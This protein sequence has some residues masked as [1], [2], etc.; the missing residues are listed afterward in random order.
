MQDQWQSNW[1]D[2]CMRST[3]KGERG[4]KVSLF[5]Q[6]IQARLCASISLP[7]GWV[8]H[9]L[10]SVLLPGP[11]LSGPQLSGLQL[12][13]RGWTMADRRFW[14]G[15]PLLGLPGSS[16]APSAANTRMQIP[17]LLITCPLKTVPGHLYSDAFYSSWQAWLLGVV[18]PIL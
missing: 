13:T 3:E 9:S 14:L 1:C 7:Y 10:C 4:N 8:G 2:Q 18:F 15:P 11:Q 16:I 12:H 17:H 6:F 5:P